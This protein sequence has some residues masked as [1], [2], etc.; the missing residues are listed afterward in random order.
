MLHVLTLALD[1]APFLTHHLATL[2]ALP[3]PWR[4]YVVEGRAQPVADTAWCRP[5]PPCLSTDGTHEWLR[6][7]GARHPRVRHKWNPLWPGKVAMCNA[8]LDDAKEPGVLLQMDADELWSW[9]QLLGIHDVLMQGPSTW[10]KFR[11]RYRVG[12]NIEADEYGNHADYDWTRAWRYHGT[13]R[14]TSHEPPVLAGNRGEC[15]PR[16]ITATCGLVFDHWSW[17]FERQVRD[18]CAYYGYGDTGFKG[19]RRLQ[20][21]GPWPARLADFL[22]WAKG[23]W[24]CRPIHKPST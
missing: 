21:N 4:W 14:F 18:K 2:D 24:Q 13:E 23:E 8:A 1:C 10:A 7:V 22:P 9:T 6:E 11:C 5:L 17:V 12:V 15:L 16:D 19:W 20:A 3:I